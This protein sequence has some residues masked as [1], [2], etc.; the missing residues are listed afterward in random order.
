MTEEK[1]TLPYVIVEQDWNYM[2][3]TEFFPQIFKIAEG[4]K[5]E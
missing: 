3:R 1:G 2:G 5:I 4:S